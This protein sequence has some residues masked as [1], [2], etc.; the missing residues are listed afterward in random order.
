MTTLIKRNKTIP[1]KKIQK[2]TTYADNQPGVQV[3]EG[4]RA[5]TK[6]NQK[7]GQFDLEGIPPQ[8]RG[9]P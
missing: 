2:F 8:P 1:T 3:F 9:L 6:E 5:S 4:D 7:L